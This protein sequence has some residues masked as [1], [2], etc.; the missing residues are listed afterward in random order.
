MKE[1]AFI[2]TM[3]AISAS[4]FVAQ[5]VVF[6]QDHSLLEMITS[7][8]QFWTGKYAITAVIISLLTNIS[9]VA[10]IKKAVK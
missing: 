7:P 9:V 2:L 5:C 6:L 1:I 10:A 8:V 3:M 4:L